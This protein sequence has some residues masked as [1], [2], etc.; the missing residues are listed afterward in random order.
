MKKKKQK[1]ITKKINKL[2]KNIYMYKVRA[3][4]NLGVT[5]LSLNEIFFDFAKKKKIKKKR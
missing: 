2:K 5:W 4:M 3:E 1:Q